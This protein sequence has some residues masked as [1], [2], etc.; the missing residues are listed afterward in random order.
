MSN[1]TIISL[2]AAILIIKGA[3]SLNIFSGISDIPCTD[4]NGTKIN[5]TDFFPSDK[6]QCTV[7]R[8]IENIVK[9]TRECP[10]YITRRPSTTTTTARPVIT[11]RTITF[12]PTTTSRPKTYPL[13][14]TANPTPIYKPTKEL[15]EDYED[16]E[17]TEPT[18]KYNPERSEHA[19]TSPEETT[20][21]EA[22]TTTTTTPTITTIHPTTTTALPTTT[23]PAT[24]RKMNSRNP[25]KSVKSNRMH[26][27][28]SN[29]M[30][31]PAVLE[32]YQIPPNENRNI[33]L[34]LLI[35]TSAIT[36]F[37]IGYLFKS[38][39]DGIKS[40]LKSREK[41]PTTPVTRTTFNYGFDF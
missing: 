39:I 22:T 15:P 9:C 27:V 1:P 10:S 25:A 28:K 30:E 23:R 7:C 26:M 17:V 2:L 40:I 3:L 38:I 16:Y 33:F 18:T 11:H 20:T 36:C 8:C 35:F 19:K 21:T 12:K 5:L 4:T 32:V 29:Y 24:V 14:V 6:I 31:E 34:P 37:T 13:F 41:V